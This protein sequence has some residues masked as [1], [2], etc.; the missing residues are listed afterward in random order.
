MTDPRPDNASAPSPTAAGRGANRGAK[1]AAERAPSARPRRA[2]GARR[3]LN[4]AG[5]KAGAAAV[6]AAY[7]GGGYLTPHLAARAGARLWCRLPHNE[8]RRKDNRPQPGRIEHVDI[9]GG[10][11]LAVETWGEPDAP[12][13]Y[14]V[15]GWGGWRG[16]VASFVPPLIASGYRAIAF[17]ALS[18]GD[19]DPGEH[20]PRH[21]S[22]GEL[23][24]SLEAI[25]RLNGPAA[26]A[27]GHSL[28]CAA[29][30][31]ASLEGALDAQRLSLVAPNPDM[32]LYARLFGQ[33]LGFPPPTI[34]LLETAV[35]KWAHRGMADFDIAS[36]GATGLLPD[37]LVIHDRA[38]RESPYRVAQ[39]IDRAWPNAQ[40]MSTQGHGH[41]RLLIAP[42]VIEAA[43]ANIFGWPPEPPEPPE[44]QEPA[45]TPEP[46][47]P[48]L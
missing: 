36:M 7:M 13:V 14:L 45:E 9:G 43:T 15:H 46:P 31:R 41:H 17:D 22:G 27:I 2:K 33:R 16:Q 42:E 32:G 3:A 37:A 19:S 44:R 39:E 24:E 10:R 1:R 18:H 12:L 11:R 20:G 34:R 48:Q 40:L 5:S 21:S 28:G 25:A 6:K 8:G 29:I 26:G 35:V 30:C 23:I 47:E 38:D 4:A